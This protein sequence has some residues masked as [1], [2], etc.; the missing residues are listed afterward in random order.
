MRRGRGSP[1][2]EA[3]G[4]LLRRL[5]LFTLGMILTGCAPERTATTDPLLGGAPL[6]RN[7]P[8]TTPPAAVAVAPPQ[9]LVGPPP[10]P[11]SSAGLSPAA[12]AA[13]PDASTL[14]IGPPPGPVSGPPQPSSVLTSAPPASGDPWHSAPPSSGATLKGP[15]MISDSPT[16]P[17]AAIA[18]PTTG[19]V[20]TS[21]FTAP[22]APRDS[23]ADLQNKLAQR[24]VM[25]QSLE[26]PD[27]QGGWRFSCGVPSREQAGAVHRIELSAAGENGLAAMRAGIDQ[28]DSYQK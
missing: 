17:I 22:P 8:L 25:F 12:L 1:R 15:E 26:G 23:Y 18:P 11:P 21:G 3:S 13:T 7:G 27:A 10:L 9:P 19:G 6:P 2:A 14:R 16:K 28:I 20:G 4:R 24:K 5:G